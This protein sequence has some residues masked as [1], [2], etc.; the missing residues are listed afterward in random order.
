MQNQLKPGHLYFLSKALLILKVACDSFSQLLSFK[1]CIALAV[2]FMSPIGFAVDELDLL[3][4][5]GIEVFQTDPEKQAQ[6]KEEKIQKRN[7]KLPPYI[8]PET[9]EADLAL[10]AV[11]LETPKEPTWSPVEYETSLTGFDSSECCLRAI[12][13]SRYQVETQCRAKGH[14]VWEIKS[15][16][17]EYTGGEVIKKHRLCNVYHNTYNQVDAATELQDTTSNL[18]SDGS[19]PD[20]VDHFLCRARSQAKCFNPT[21]DNEIFRT[22]Q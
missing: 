19:T 14:Q 22:N 12:R 4:A 6:A 15:V 20:S 18:A 8:L 3:E 13:S 1:L 21:G 2:G 16:E 10:D 11:D 5:F 7:A 9:L 17:V